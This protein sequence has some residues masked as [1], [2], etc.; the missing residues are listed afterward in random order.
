M[1]TTQARQTVDLKDLP[2]TTLQGEHTTFGDIVGDR[3]ALVVNVASRCG[4]SPQYEQLEAL[5]K[6]YAD[7]GFTVIGFPCRQFLGQEL[8]SE[9]AIEEYCSTTWGVTFPMSARIKVNGSQTDPIY[10][11]LKDFPREEDG[12]DGRITWNFEKFVVS[13]DG[14]VTRFS[15]TTKPDEPQVINAIEK[16]LS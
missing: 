5:Q 8:K 3:T 2:V 9:R 6:K 12:K 11:Q 4:L 14:H 1:T 15:P 7:R 13:R 16:T 10:V